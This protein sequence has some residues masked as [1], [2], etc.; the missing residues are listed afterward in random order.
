MALAN[1]SYQPVGLMNYLYGTSSALLATGIH[2]ALS[3]VSI[4]HLSIKLV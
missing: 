1:L 2:S 3:P 4:Q